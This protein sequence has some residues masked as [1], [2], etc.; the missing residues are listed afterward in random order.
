VLEIIGKPGKRPGDIM[1]LALRKA[2][3]EIE[4]RS[5]IQPLNTA[6][7]ERVTI[8]AK[9]LSL[10]ETRLFTRRDGTGGEMRGA[11]IGDENGTARLVCWM[12]EVLDELVPGTSLRITGAVNRSRPPARE[13]SVDEKSTIEPIEK[14]IEVLMSPISGVGDEG[15]YSVGGT[16]THVLP[17]RSFIA[18]DGSRSHVRNI[19][20]RDD[21]G[22]IRVVFWGDTAVK[23][24]FEGD[25]IRIYN[26]AARVGRTG[27][28]ELSVGR[29]SSISVETKAAGQPIEIQ[30][31]ILTDMSATLIDD[32]TTSYILEGEH[33]YGRVVRV[34]GTL[35]GHT[36]TPETIEAVELSPE[37]VLTRCRLLKEQIDRA[38]S[39]GKDG[40][41]H[42]PEI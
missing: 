36:I 18:K 41:G 12:P 21:T 16:I 38:Q 30:G 34:T 33:P 31:T 9:L 39:V 7:A 13:Y 42:T 37:K 15:M 10:D 3:C 28:R 1:A 24:Y 20:V 26:A 2:S 29:G 11:V 17:A 19:L 23:H 14:E 40:P 4:C 27:E 32:G 25:T 35:N 8:E 22:L 6:P 5:N